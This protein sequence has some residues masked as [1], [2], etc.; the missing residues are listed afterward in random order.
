MLTLLN[1]HMVSLKAHGNGLWLARVIVPPTA[2][3]SEEISELQ[4]SSKEANRLRPAFV[5][6]KGKFLD[7]LSRC[8]R[9]N[10]GKLTRDP[11]V[12]SRWFHVSAQTPL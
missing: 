5:A 6:V 12:I 1:G 7:R 4:I 11:Y 2:L 9:V 3:I 10:G 8:E